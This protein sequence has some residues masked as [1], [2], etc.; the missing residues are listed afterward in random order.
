[1]SQK[2]LY[3]SLALLL[4]TSC[5]QDELL[6]VRCG[7]ACIIDVEGTIQ[8]IEDDEQYNIGQCSSGI[9]ECSTRGEVCTG[10]T[11]PSAEICDGVDNDCNGSIDDS[12]PI[13]P[14]EPCIFDE[15]NNIVS[16]SL[17]P[18]G[19]CTNGVVECTMYGE[20][21]C[22]GITNPQPEVCDGLDNNCDGAVDND[23]QGAPELSCP[24]VGCLPQTGVC[25][26]GDWVCPGEDS[27]GDE[28]CDGLDNDCDGLVDEDEPG[29]PLFNNGTFVYDGDIEET[30]N[31]PCRPGVRSCVD[32]VEVILGMVTPSAE[33]CDGIDNDCD[34]YVDNDP[35]DTYTESYTGPA[36]TNGVGNCRPASQ[37]CV[38]GSLVVANE[39][40]PIPED[41]S[42]VYD[43]DCDGFINEEPT[44]AVSQ[45]FVL[46]LDIS[47]SMLYALHPMMNAL[48]DWSSSSYLDGS[49]FNI[50]VVGNAISEDNRDSNIPVSLTNG[51]KT[52]SGVCDALFGPN[53]YGSFVSSGHEPQFAGVEVALEYPWPYGMTRNVIV[54]SDEGLQSPEAHSFGMFS[55]TERDDFQQHC[56]DYNYRLIVYADDYFSWWEDLTDVCGGTTH[57]LTADRD[58]LLAMLLEDF[59]GNC[60]DPANFQ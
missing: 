14:G 2:Y 44:E 17:E 50:V 15:D 12:F 56:V 25:R 54:F 41:C 42:D 52:A 47:G 57:Q 21:A 51:F 5:T 20:F 26:D 33:V 48:C 18:V 53:G 28:V 43:N 38:D 35:I 1:M 40:L 37:T 11:T 19:T 49:K 13:A 58:E 4:C 9:L 22:T 29:D 8:L 55:V 32:G 34:G 27:L 24:A 36:G 31:P 3:T 46:V 23:P 60:A 7:K 45:A 30:S 39:V 59:V 6:T 10:Y 16:P